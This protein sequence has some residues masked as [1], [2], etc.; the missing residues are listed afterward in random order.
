MG[1]VSWC[2]S[3]SMVETMKRLT[4]MMKK[5]GLVGFSAFLSAWIP[6]HSFASINDWQCLTSDLRGSAESRA[7]FIAAS[8]EAS[9]LFNISP[10]M[11]VAIKRVESGRSLD[12]MVVGHNRNGTVDRGYYQVNTEV[13]MPELRRIGADLMVADLH[14][15]RKNALIAGW[16]LRRKMNRSDIHGPIEA[17]GYY[18]KGGGADDVSRRIRQVYIDKFMTELRVI[19]G[20]CGG[21]NGLQAALR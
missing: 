20:R 16:I 7:S 15:V 17:V 5:I 8:S 12:P 3:R 18:H 11:L 19:V 1:M 2:L 9:R 14:S 10:A 4:R 21:R 13:W 6:A